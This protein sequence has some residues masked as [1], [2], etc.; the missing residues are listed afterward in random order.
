[1]FKSKSKSQKMR[2]QA[3]EVA[4]D[5]MGRL[6]PHV[7]S[8][9]EKA[10]PMIADARE[11]A[12]PVLAEA[13]LKAAPVIAEARDR[14]TP[15]L[16]TAKTKFTT[17]VLPVVTAAVASA[18]EATEDARAEARR[19]GLATAA[20]LKGEIEAPHEK[21]HKLRNLLVFTGLAGLV[22]M[23]ARRLSDREASTAW[24]S[25]YTP[26]PA[27]GTSSSTTPTPSAPQ[28][29]LDDETPLGTAAAAAATSDDEGGAGPDEAAADATDVPHTVTTPD[30]PAEEIDVEGESKS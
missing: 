22:A 24:Q 7:D 21:G 13:K 8:A 29:G 23:I 11:K 19:R 26:T 3:S 5:L 17:E 1:M 16:D 20:A 4:G 27:T 2:E 28:A 15:A 30:A 12:A 25:S 6:A 14:A 18:A 9:R 10:A